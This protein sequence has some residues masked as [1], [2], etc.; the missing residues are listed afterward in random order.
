MLIGSKNT[1]RQTKQ[2]YTQCISASKQNKT[3][4]YYAPSTVQ[5]IKCCMHFYEILR[6]IYSATYKVLHAFFEL[7]NTTKSGFIVFICIYCHVQNVYINCGELTCYCVFLFIVTCILAKVIFAFFSVS[8]ISLPLIKIFQHT[9]FQV[10]S[11]LR[12]MLIQVT[13]VRVNYKNY[14]SVY[15]RYTLD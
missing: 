6:T 10:L 12:R 15:M 14:L 4:K 7:L 3:A 13:E 1:E 5:P 2:Y 9:V 8:C 11:S